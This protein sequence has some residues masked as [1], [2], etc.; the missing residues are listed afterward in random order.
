MRVPA[1][2]AAIPLLAGSAAGVLFVDYVPERL[3]LAF[4]ASAL[5]ALMAGFGFFEDGLCL[6]SGAIVAAGFAAAGMSMGLSSAHALHAPTLL[7]WLPCLSLSLAGELN[8]GSPS[9]IRLS[10]STS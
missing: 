1:A 8:S 5:F 10:S 4:A 3:I 7:Q 9:E 2:V 6:V